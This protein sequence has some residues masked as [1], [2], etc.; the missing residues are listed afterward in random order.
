M[1]NPTVRSDLKYCAVAP[2]F[3]TSVVFQTD[4]EI[5]ELVDALRKVKSDNAGKAN[6]F[7]HVHLQ[8][9]NLGEN[10]NSEEGEIMFFGPLFHSTSGNEAKEERIARNKFAGEARCFL[11]KL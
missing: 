8:D 4:E 1:V 6:W 2:H 11:D 7:R 9:Y 3:W 10:A 5:D